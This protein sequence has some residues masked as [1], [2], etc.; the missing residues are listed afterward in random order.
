MALQ[1]QHS[2]WA[3]RLSAYMEVLERKLVEDEYL[4]EGTLTVFAGIP[5]GKD[6]PYNYLEAKR[7]L[8]LAM[9][10]LRRR[11]D[12][13]QELGVD[14]EGKGRPA[15]TGS[16]TTRV[17]DFL[18]LGIAKD[19]K[20]FT[21]FPHLTLSIQQDNLVAL[22]IVPHGIRREFR[23]RLLEDGKDRF[24]RL[25]QTIFNNL[26][27][28]I[29]EIEGAAPW[30]EIIQRRYPSQRTEPIID[31]RLHFDLRTA[32][33]DADGQPASVKQQPQW[34]AA[35]YEAL[36]AKNSIKNVTTIHVNTEKPNAVGP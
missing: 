24:H 7:L 26:N 12:L 1:E 5:F 21:E 30:I 16:E 28:S 15:I 9:E 4:K 2:E 6:R 8:R 35:S 18:P 29:G 13:N 10:D 33:V 32:F 31:A 19:A 20:N 27:Q 11:N 3:C 23:N 17:W 34:L 14:S 22:V 25:F 36:S